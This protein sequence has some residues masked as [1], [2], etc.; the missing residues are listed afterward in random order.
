MAQPSDE[1]APT[2]PRDLRFLK[3]LV[4][5]LTAVMI[6]GVITIIALLVIRLNSPA[7]PVLVHPELFDLPA[8]VQTVGYSVLGNRV[9]IITDDGVIRVFDASDR[10]LLQE[11]PL[12]Q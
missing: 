3:G 12:A 1:D 4:T 11:M 5:V 8:G 6:F 9:V 2:L 10:A 7:P